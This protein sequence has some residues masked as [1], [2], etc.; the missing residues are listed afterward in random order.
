MR[1]WGMLKALF[2]CIKSATP[3]PF[4]SAAARLYSA[5]VHRL[6]LETS[7]KLRYFKSYQRLPNL[8]QPKLFSEKCQA[9]KLAQ[10]D[11]SRFVDKVAVKQFVRERIGD[12]YVIPTLY[13]G[14]E[15]PPRQ[16]RNW[17]RPYVIKTNHGSGGNIFVRDEPDWD[18][19][20]AKLAVFTNYDFSAVSGE[21]FYSGFPRQVLVEPF[22]GQA[23]ELP[24]D[25]KIFT[26]GGEPQFIQVDTDREFAH[27]R[28]FFD[29]HWNRLP[30]RLGYPEDPSP[31]PRPKRLEKLLE[32]ASVLGTDIGFVRI[33]F[34][35][36]CGR[37]YFGE[38]TFTPESG[39]MKFEPASVDA[40]LGAKWPWPPT[41]PD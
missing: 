8:S 33:D 29:H 20:E 38:M 21:T 32:L 26:C 36:I 30:I 5:M 15:L 4:R 25:Y 9:L 24:I 23:K 37:V 41:W 35:E 7:L 1:I 19:I 12:Q 22:V 27:K 39:L 3:G 6:P 13:A 31:I 11:L 34:Y 28:V 2:R 14:E 16:E 17:P 10:P 40:H 18:A